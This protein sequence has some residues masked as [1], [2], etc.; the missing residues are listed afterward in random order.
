MALIQVS[1]CLLDSPDIFD[2]LLDSF[3]KVEVVKNE[4]YY[5][6][7]VLR[8]QHEE[9]T[10]EDTVICPILYSFEGVRPFII[11]FDA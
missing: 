9:V 4:P 6:R 3:E 10:P 1:Y 2:I 11:E 5:K 7:K 8:V